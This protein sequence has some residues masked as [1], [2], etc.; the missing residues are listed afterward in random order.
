MQ[1]PKRGDLC[2]RCLDGG[3]FVIDATTD[4]RLEGPFLREAHAIGIAQSLATKRRA[5][6]WREN[7]DERGISFG[8]PKIILP[9][10]R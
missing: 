10:I 6:V 5:N 9:T 3:F 1:S 2:I 7:V 4:A 8:P